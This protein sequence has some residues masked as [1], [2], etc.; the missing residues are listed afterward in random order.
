MADFSIRRQVGAA[1]DVEHVITMAHELASRQLPLLRTRDPTISTSASDKLNR[2]L[3]KHFF[4]TRNAD[5]F[6]IHHRK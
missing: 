6:V 2:K 4:C 3:R 1:T 5:G